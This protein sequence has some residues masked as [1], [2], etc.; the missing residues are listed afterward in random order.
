[1][2]SWLDQSL[3]CESTLG[4]RAAMKHDVRQWREEQERQQQERA[5]AA[6][7]SAEA[8]AAAARAAQQAVNAAKR[9]QARAY[10]DIKACTSFWTL[11]GQ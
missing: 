2:S 4:H 1:M 10:K 11:L 7:S 9:A 8:A 6:R 3:E 5:E